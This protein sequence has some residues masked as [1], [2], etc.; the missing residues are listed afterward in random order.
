[1]YHIHIDDIIIGTFYTIECSMIV[2]TKQ[3]ERLPLAIEDAILG[4]RRL[5]NCI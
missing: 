1:M 5:H 2:A 3:E 4:F